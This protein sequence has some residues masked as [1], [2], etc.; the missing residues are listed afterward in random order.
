MI[1][2]HWTSSP[3]HAQPVPREHN[4][5]LPD[6]ER[7]GVEFCEMLRAGGND[8]WFLLNNIDWPL[9]LRGD[10]IL[11]NLLHQGGK[12]RACRAGCRLSPDT[13]RSSHSHQP[14]SATILSILVS[15]NL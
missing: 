1:I 7:T 6:L 5:Y 4:T 9:S 12:G 14:T 11:V 10:T 3:D 15:G 13:P 8:R 2:P